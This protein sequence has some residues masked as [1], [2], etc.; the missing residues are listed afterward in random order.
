[1]KTSPNSHS[2]FANSLPTSVR[3]LEGVDS[4]KALSIILGVSVAAILF[5]VWLIYFKAPALLK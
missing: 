3:T 5:L 1:M 4:R 2:L